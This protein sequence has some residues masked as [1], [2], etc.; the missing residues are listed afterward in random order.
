MTAGRPAI[1]GRQAAILD[2][3]FTDGASNAPIKEL[4]A[5]INGAS[6]RAEL[7]IFDAVF[8]FM[9]DIS[10]AEWEEDGVVRA[11]VVKLPHHGHADSMSLSVL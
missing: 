3:L 2:R 7:R 8:L 10:A 4:D 1:Y 5:F 11:D 9:G 6:L